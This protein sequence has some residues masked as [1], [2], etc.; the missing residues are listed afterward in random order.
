MVPG[1]LADS[2]KEPKF[3]SNFGEVRPIIT[4]TKATQTRTHSSNTKEHAEAAQAC[5]DLDRTFSRLLV[6]APLR[7]TNLC[8]CCEGMI[9]P[10]LTRSS[11]Q[12][13]VCEGGR[14][15]RRGMALSFSA[16]PKMANKPWPVAV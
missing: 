2:Y 14:I 4:N 7:Q 9:P 3:S 12:E 16:Y 5:I 8:F 6:F 13:R 15:L 10:L 11:S 1:A